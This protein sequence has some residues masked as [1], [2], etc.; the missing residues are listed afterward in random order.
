MRLASRLR[1]ALVEERLYRIDRW[2]A[3]FSLVQVE[4]ATSPVD[5]FLNINTPEDLAAAEAYLGGSGIP[6]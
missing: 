2:T 5:P 3:R 6:R 4:F 1:R